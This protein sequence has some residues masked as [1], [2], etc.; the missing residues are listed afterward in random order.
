MNN[1]HTVCMNDNIMRWLVIVSK[2]FYT[3][4]AGQFYKTICSLYFI[5]LKVN[6]DRAQLFCVFC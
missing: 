1:I 3:L 6:M 5:R 2:S 4:A